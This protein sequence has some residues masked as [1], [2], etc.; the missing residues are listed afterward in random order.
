MSITINE[1]PGNKTEII[2]NDTIKVT[3]EENSFNATGEMNV[4][5]DIDQYTEEQVKEIVNQYIE[6]VL[7]RAVELEKNKK[8]Q[9]EQ[10]V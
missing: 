5:Y 1:T 8:N 3:L 2:I 7:L 10:Q 6:Q 9:P 4:E